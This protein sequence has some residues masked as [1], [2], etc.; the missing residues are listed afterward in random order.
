MVADSHFI[1]YLHACTISY[2][3]RACW[4][5]LLSFLI[6]HPNKLNYNTMINK[7]QKLI[8][9]IYN[10]DTKPQFISF[11]RQKKWQG[12]LTKPQGLFKFRFLHKSL[13][14]H[15]PL[16]NKSS[17]SPRSPSEVSY[18]IGEEWIIW[19]EL[20]AVVQNLLITDLASSS[21]R[22]SSGKAWHGNY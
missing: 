7:L 19:Q 12:I 21:P 15:V 5:M 13:N 20:Y 10:K 6:C 8:D 18:T 3:S 11:K 1:G 17:F 9:N 16:K 14:I 22:L 4:M 2:P